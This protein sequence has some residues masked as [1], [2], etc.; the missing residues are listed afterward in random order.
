M[1]AE[2]NQKQVSSAPTALGNRKLRD[3]HIPTA[4]TKQWKSGNQKQVSHFPTTYDLPWMTK[5]R[6]R[7]GGGASLLLQAHCSI[8]ICCEPERELVPS[9]WKVI[10]ATQR[11]RVDLRILGA[12][13]RRVRVSRRGLAAGGSRP[14]VAGLSVG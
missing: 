9:C 10:S 6:R 11:F 5:F 3:S 8:R 4:A 7:P 12:V 2:E 14:A 1:D 13:V